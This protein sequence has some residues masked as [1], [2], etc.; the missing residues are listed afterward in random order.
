MATLRD[1][2][3]DKWTQK[4]IKMTF[5]YAGLPDTIYLYYPHVEGVTLIG[6]QLPANINQNK[7]SFGANNNNKLEQQQGFY[8]FAKYKKSSKNTFLVAFTKNLYNI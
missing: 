5:G 6:S 7:L 2:Q 3:M 1:S 4:M 8:F